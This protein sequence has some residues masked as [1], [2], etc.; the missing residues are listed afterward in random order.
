[1]EAEYSLNC[2]NCGE[3]FH[4]TDGFPKPQY[5][6]NCLVAFRAGKQDGI[7]E[8]VERNKKEILQKFDCL[9]LAP[10]DDVYYRILVEDV[11]A[12]IRTGKNSAQR[13]HKK[14]QAFQEQGEK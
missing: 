1:M 3:L 12:E 5:C 8:A 9:K 11:L 2:D 14:W 10:D 6:F 7:K 4:S 13:A